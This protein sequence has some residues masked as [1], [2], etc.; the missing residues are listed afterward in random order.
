M[1]EAFDI[2]PRD[3]A[4]PVSVHR[5]CEHIAFLFHL[6]EQREQ[7]PVPAAPL[8]LL[9]DEKIS[10]HHLHPKADAKHR[11]AG[12]GSVL[13]NLKMVRIKSCPAAKHKCVAERQTI[14]RSIAV[15]AENA[16]RRCAVCKNALWIAVHK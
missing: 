4:V 16:D 14:L 7:R 13:H 1:L 3:M 6:L 11:L 12:F 10:V 8:R 5:F 2:V 15:A 9:G